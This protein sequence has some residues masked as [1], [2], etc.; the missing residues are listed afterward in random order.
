MST[1][2]QRVKE[3]R[4]QF[5]KLVLEQEKE[6]LDIYEEAAKQIQYMLS[7]AKAGG[8]SSRY[9]SELDKSINQYLSELR[10]SLTS[11]IK[12]GIEASAQIASAVQ[13]SY[14]DSISPREDILA[15]FNKMFSQLPT[16]VLKQ[17]IGG[18]YYADGKTLNN[19]IWDLTSKNAKDIDTLIKINVAKGVNA[20]ELAKQLDA[21]IDPNKRIEAKTIEAGM[22]KNISYQAQRLSRTSL[23]HAHNESYIQGAKM[24]PF[25]RGMKWN[26]SPSHYERQVKRWGRDIC[27]EYARRD[28]Y[29]RGQGVYPA[30]KYPVAH[31]NC[32]CYPTQENAPVER[33]RE[34][35]IGWLNGGSN[36][37]LDRWVDDYGKDFGIDI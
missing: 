33:A 32:L 11:S 29:A 9:L 13:L 30:D 4:K 1:Y 17:V 35:I 16:S 18:N 25:C 37:H 23:T 36:A 5:L 27:D 14:F 24:N 19:R 34:E 6:I 22:S 8:L 31:P 20:R 15:T 28:N 7:K 21:Y 26:L 2:S 12:D 3:G 10:N